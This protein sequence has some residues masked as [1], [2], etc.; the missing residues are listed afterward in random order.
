MPVGWGVEAEVDELGR[1]TEYEYNALGQLVRKILPDPDGDG[2]LT[3]P[4]YQ[5][6]YDA[7]GNLVA[8]TD[9]L[10]N[11][12]Q[13][14]YDARG[15][16]IRTVQPDPDGENGPLTS[17]ITQQFYDRAGRL[18][19]V[20]DPVGTITEYAY[21]NADR[22]TAVYHGA[23]LD[24]ADANYAETGPTWTDRQTGYGDLSRIHPTV[25]GDPTATATW[26]FSHLLVG[27]EYEVYVTWEADPDN[28]SDAPFA[29]FAGDTSGQPLASITVDQ[30][31]DPGQ[32]GQ[33]REFAGL[34]FRKLGSFTLTD[35]TLIVQLA[36]NSATANKNVVADAVVV[37]LASPLSQTIYDNAGRVVGSL[38]ALG[39]LTTYEYDAAGRQTKI[40]Q[41]DPDGT[42]PLEAPVTQYVY[43]TGGQLVQVI[44]PLGR[45]TAY[46]YDALGRRSKVILPDPD[47]SG[48]LTSPE[49]LY[50]YDKLGRLL[51][52]SDPL[53][54]VTEYEYDARGRQIRVTQP[55][56]DGSG[57]LEAPV[58][59][60]TY[61]A[62]G[63]LLQVTDPLD[64]VTSYEYDGLGRQTKITQPDPDGE[65]E[66]LAPWTVFTYDAAGRLL[67][68][69]DRLGHTTTFTYDA[70]GRLIS[71]TDANGAETTYTYDAAGR[72]LSLTDPVG[73]TTTWTYDALGRAVAETNEL[74]D[75]RYFVYDAAGYLLRQIDRL[76]RVR[77]FQ[78]DNLGRNTA[79][80]WYNNV[81]DAD[82]DQ[83]RQ[84]T[85][86]FTYD[87][88]GQLTSVDDVEA[89]Y[90]YTY[91]ALGRVITLTHSIVGLTP[92]VTFNQTYDAVGRRTELKTQ[93]NGTAEFVNQWTYDNLGRVIRITQG[94]QPGG[95]A[96]AEKRVDLTYDA[97]GQL[98]SLTRYADLA[99]TQLVAQSDYTYDQAGRLRGLS[100]FRGQTTFVEYT[101]NFDAANR[102]T[103]YI[104]SVD[105]TADYT[106]DATG[107]LT[108]ADYDYQ[109][110][111]SYQYDANGNRVTAN[112]STYTTGTNN[113]LLSDGTYRYLYD[114]EGNRTHRFID[115]N[116]NGQLDA[117]DTDITQ[118]TW[119]HRNRLTK[120]SHRPSY[121]AAVDWVIRYWY[122][123][124][125]RMVRKLGDLN[126]DGDY[127]QKQNLVY[128]GNQVVMDFRRTGSGLV[129]TGD[130]EWRYLWG[131]AVDQILAEENVDNGADETVQWTLTDHLNTVRDIAK[132][133]PGSDMT[134][135]VNH[136]VY[137]AF[138]RVTS[139]SNPAV[140]SLFLFTGRPFDSDTRL[141]SNINRWYDAHVGRWLS[142]D[143]IGFAG[144]DGNL[145]RYVGNGTLRSSDPSGKNPSDALW[146]YWNNGRLPKAW[147]ID[148]TASAV[149]GT[150]FAGALQIVFFG[151]TCEFGLFAIGP[152]AANPTM[153]IVNNPLE[154][155]KHAAKRF[156]LD[157]PW[158]YDI[159]L[160]ANVTVAYSNL[161]G[162][163]Y[164]DAASW[165]GV[166]YGANVDIGAGPGVG[167]GG[168]VSADGHWWGG[169]LGA[170]VS[171]PG[172]GFR[173]N[174]QYVY[175]L[176]SIKLK[177]LVGDRAAMCVCYSL[178]AGLP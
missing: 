46:E 42:G 178:V 79:E 75:T 114:A 116:A 169:S 13:Y 7:M 162:E 3:S 166:S 14:V 12:T 141:Q 27:M 89:D 110:D 52:V 8:E 125:N 57:P 91:D 119:D 163:Q 139:E 35:P 32:T 100:H 131:P 86:T 53:G 71:Q 134:T 113:R 41:P 177:D 69:A 22:Q 107:Q 62:A 142:E 123:Y 60:Y 149:L 64:R 67:T 146:K 106:S 48:P 37:R 152:A 120:V 103:Q 50:E 160:S 20:I 105:G 93:V 4:I 21:D 39:R 133:N 23:L 95:R 81:Q 66:E 77:Q 6:S 82:A 9:P 158:G 68:Q 29:I 34:T 144:G 118:Y 33:F 132:Y 174:P 92:M 5:Y 157:L 99:G 36:N 63:Q 153:P 17:P 59:Q 19:H 83:N 40:I 143:P 108:A 47:G 28:A 43:T 85:I 25:T 171:V 137:D 154:L 10:G 38:D 15:R 26:T 164:A 147:A 72:R 117:G 1:R 172:S 97:A 109:S 173:T 90:T 161:Q 135:V 165:T 150:G 121:G 78:Y 70:L 128:D 104:N 24:N 102:M 115:A 145:Y 31:Q 122:D 111:E 126:G 148:L 94:P 98:V 18:S 16:L 51:K 129:Q 87:L 140:D 84:R 55:D 159:S 124:Q 76:G 80:I 56:P 127:E 45:V 138:G 155:L 176:A 30:S 11:V 170:G 96:V 151:D 73:N 58:T 168:F 44:D 88:V 101:W 54:N 175:R 65:G 167:G 136:L 130:L 156:F 74:D 61:D 112:G 2:P 49:T